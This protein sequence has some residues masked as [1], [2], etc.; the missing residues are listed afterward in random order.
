MMVRDSHYGRDH[1]DAKIQELEESIVSLSEGVTPKDANRVLSAR[2]S[3]HVE[4]LLCRY[5]AG[6]ALGVVAERLADS[7][8]GLADAP[9]VDPTTGRSEVFIWL[10]ALCVLF[11]DSSSAAKLCERAEATGFEDYL[12]DH[13]VSAVLG[14]SATVTGAFCPRFD[15]GGSGV[16]VGWVLGDWDRYRFGQP[17]SDRLRRSR[18]SRSPCRY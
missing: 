9:Q 1:F 10:A 18:R 2:W 17:S 14:G 12:F 16:G 5:S 15:R 8:N 6:D 11:E 7:A 13:F 3:R 4:I